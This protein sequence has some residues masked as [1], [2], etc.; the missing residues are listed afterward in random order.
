MRRVTA[1]LQIA[2]VGAATCDE[3]TAALAHAVGVELARAGAVLVSG[4]RGG[5]MSAAC[6]GAQSAGGRTVGVL[7]GKDASDSSPNEHLDV[8]LFT[9][10]Q[11]ARNQILVLSSAAVI[12]IG[13]GWG[14]LSEIAMALKYRVPVVLLASWH[15]RR[16]DGLSDPLLLAARTAAD[17]VALATQASA[18]DRPITVV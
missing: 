5:V 6:A 7:P 1:P 15:L 14:T 8:V 4:G 2:V 10:F 13:G 11:Q 9:G 17:A 16:P 18:R 3:A 12:A